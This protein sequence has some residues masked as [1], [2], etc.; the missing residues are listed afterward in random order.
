MQARRKKERTK[1]KK[2][3]FPVQDDFEDMVVVIIANITTCKL[4]K[5]RFGKNNFFIKNCC[6]IKKLRI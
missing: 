1:N 3:G 4:L 5:V 2:I 6:K